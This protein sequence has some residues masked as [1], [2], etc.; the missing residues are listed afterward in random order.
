M[1]KK[2]SLHPECSE[3]ASTVTTKAER[4][5]DQGQQQENEGD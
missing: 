4:G 2:R 5:E 1:N 3:S